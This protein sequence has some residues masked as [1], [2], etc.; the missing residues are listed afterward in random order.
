LVD[1]LVRLWDYDWVNLMGMISVALL[2]GLQTS[3]HQTSKKGARNQQQTYWTHQM[4]QS[5][6]NLLEVKVVVD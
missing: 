5:M 6:E 3:E 1:A 2:D 4:G